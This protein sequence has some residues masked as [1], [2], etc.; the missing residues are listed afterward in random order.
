[1]IVSAKLGGGVKYSESDR[2]ANVEAQADCTCYPVNLK[3]SSPLQLGSILC[4]QRMQL[5]LWLLS[6]GIGFRPVCR[7]LRADYREDKLRAA[8]LAAVSR[9][10]PP[11]QRRGTAPLGGGGA[12]KHAGVARAAKYVLSR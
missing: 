9:A 10:A 1:M 2:D 7:A 11:R 6:D 12:N 3:V 5:R 8:V 4:E